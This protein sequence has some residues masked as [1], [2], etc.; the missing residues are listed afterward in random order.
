MDHDK[1]R[2]ASE[3]PLNGPAASD[4]LAAS[5]G[6]ELPGRATD[7]DPPARSRD[8]DPGD[9]SAARLEPIP[10]EVDHTTAMS[11]QPGIVGTTGYGADVPATDDP[12]VDDALANEARWSGGGVTPAREKK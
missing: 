6:L 11:S 2:R 8:Q 10:G 5:S 4:S 9:V 7:P 1:M 3:V 12:T